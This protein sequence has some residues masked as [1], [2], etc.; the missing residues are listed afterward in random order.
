VSELT[1]P[2]RSGLQRI[3]QAMAAQDFARAAT[4]AADLVRASPA[5]ALAH[6]MHGAALA[7]S[8][9]LDAAE[10][11]LREAI[12]LDPSLS[13]AAVRLGMMLVDI[14]RA[15][16][17]RAVIAPFAD[18]EPREQGKLHNSQND[19]EPRGCGEP[20]GHHQGRQG[21]QRDST[22]GQHR[23]DQNINDG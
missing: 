23:S 21:R 9:R 17:T 4:L 8:G 10:K 15:A 20:A 6:Y 5:L 13:W 11:A 22:D 18:T 3:S 19:C 1:L 2:E 16:E 14:G 7:S 12:R